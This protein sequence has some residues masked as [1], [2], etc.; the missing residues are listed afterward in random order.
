MNIVLLGLR[1][2]G[3]TTVGTRLAA[4]LGRGFVD[5]D[6]RTLAL[7]GCSRVIEAWR[8]HGEEAFR[9][10]EARAL[11]EVLA[12]AD[13]VIALGGGTP[14]AP[15]AATMLEDARATGAAMIYLAADAAL[16]GSRLSA[17]GGGDRPPLLGDDAIDEIGAVLAAREPLYRRL[18]Q[19]TLDAAKDPGEQA[20]AIAQLLGLDHAPGSAAG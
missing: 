3:K 12:R 19:F 11:A 18:A 8:V 7:L 14:T 1:G 15:G 17:D 13:H 4:L 16:L 6:E 2:S 20:A 9:A 10:A 5:L